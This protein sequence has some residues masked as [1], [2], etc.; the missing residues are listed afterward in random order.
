MSYRPTFV[1]TV[2]PSMVDSGTT[3][4][5]QPYATLK[6]ATISRPG[7]PDV[8]RTIMAFGPAAGV[9][10]ALVQGAPVPLA[11]QN[12][13]ATLRLIGLPRAA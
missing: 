11:V 10:S 8:V 2:T 4:G 13:G 1:A 9:A 3:E 5:G 6:D 12:N 7:K